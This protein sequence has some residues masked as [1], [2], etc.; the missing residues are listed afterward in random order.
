M[1]GRGYIT[2]LLILAFILAGWIAYTYFYAPLWS[3][4]L[5]LRQQLETESVR[6]ATLN[7]LNRYQPT[8]EVRKEV[9]EER[10]SLLDK[11]LGQESET[12]T[13]FVQLEQLATTYGVKITS[14]SNPS[15]PAQVD[16]STVSSF[17]MTIEGDYFKLLSFLRALYYFPRVVDVSAL[18]IEGGGEQIK[19][20]LDCVIYLKPGGGG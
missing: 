3:E 14:L 17:Q 7:E 11:L 19:A 13:L 15:A 12:P 20:A 6:L 10:I 9:F 18:S 5:K 4:N 1:R 8:L 2:V 16:G